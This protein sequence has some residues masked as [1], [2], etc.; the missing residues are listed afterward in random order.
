MRRSIVRCQTCSLAYGQGMEHDEIRRRYGQLMRSKQIR[1]LADF[2]FNL[3]IVGRDTYVAGE[4]GVRD[5]ERL[6]SINEVQHRV[7]AHLLELATEDDKRYPDEVLFSIVLEHDD[8]Q[9]R[10]RTLW[11]LNDA[12][13]RHGA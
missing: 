9:L 8:E 1:V 7:L 4:L 11:A 6:R 5:P 2:G 3:T 13:D 12:L 10:V